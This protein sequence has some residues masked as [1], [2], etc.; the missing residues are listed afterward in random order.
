MMQQYLEIVKAPTEE[1]LSSERQSYMR[2]SMIIA[3]KDL[4]WALAL[5]RK[6]GIA[7]PA[8]ALVSQ[9]MIRKQ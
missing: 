8:A 5:A 4:A 6:S 7:M 2:R 9:Y 1:I 3:E